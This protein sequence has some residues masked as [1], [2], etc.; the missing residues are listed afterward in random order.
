MQRT[1]PRETLWSVQTPQAFRA[2]L[3]FRAFEK[4]KK[5]GFKGTDES[6]LVERLGERVAIV[7]GSYE[8]IKITTEEDMAIAECVLNKRGLSTPS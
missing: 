8:N 3:L 7:M 2:E 6:S 5:D 4:A 1:I